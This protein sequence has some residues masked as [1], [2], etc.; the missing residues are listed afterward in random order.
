MILNELE[1]RICGI[2][3]IVKYSTPIYDRG[4]KWTPPEWTFDT[5]I[6]CDRNGREAEWLEQKMTREDHDEVLDKIIFKE[7]GY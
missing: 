3:A 6:I 1:T 2:P 7:R 4:C 5:V